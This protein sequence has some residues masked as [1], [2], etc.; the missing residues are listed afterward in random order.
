[1]GRGLYFCDLKIRE[2]YTLCSQNFPD[3]TPLAYLPIDEISDERLS[4]DT[5]YKTTRHFLRCMDPTKNVIDG[6]REP[7][8]D[9]W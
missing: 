2:R 9:R 8:G 4:Q 6:N 7:R 1:V 3:I 5:V